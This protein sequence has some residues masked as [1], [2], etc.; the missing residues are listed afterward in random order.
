MLCGI[1]FFQKVVALQQKY[2]KSGQRIQNDLQTNGTLL[3]EAWC[4]FLKE[5]GFLVGV[6]IDGPRKLH[7]RY[8]VTRR[9][10]PTFDRVMQAIK[11]LQRFGAPFNTLTC[12]NRFNAR[13]PIDIYRFLRDEVGSTRMQFTP[14][15]EYQGFD[16]MSLAEVDGQR[17]VKDGDPEARPDHPES[18]VTDWSVDPDDWGYFLCRMFDRWAARDVGKIFVNQFETLMAQHMGEPSQMC[19]YSECC[20]KGVAVE[21]DGSVYA[22]DHFVYPDYRIGDLRKGRLRD[23]VLSRGQVKFGYAKSESL[24]KQCR[25]C[26]FLSD[27]R[28]ECPKNR[29]GLNYLCTGFK[30]FFDH[31]TPEVDRI[32]GE[33]QRDPPPFLFGK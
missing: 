26:P 33:L 32:A 27:C 5:N 14:V 10:E 9:G 24:P 11:L 19:V 4:E 8:R 18:I 20:G 21:H 15:V 12:V 17:L 1:E 29:P 22:C 6:S 30:T 3:D 25:A 28:G 16:R 7:D 23:A 2:A 31:A 13:K